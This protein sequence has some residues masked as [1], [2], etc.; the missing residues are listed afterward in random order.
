MQ[1]CVALLRGRVNFGA[2]RQ[3]LLDDADVAFLGCQVQRVE[4]IL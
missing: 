4:A 3:K 1:G 2:P